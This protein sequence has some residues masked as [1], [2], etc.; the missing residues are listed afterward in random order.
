M[1]V[2]RGTNHW[3]Q[4][5]PKTHAYIARTIFFPTNVD[6]IVEAVT[7]AESMFTPV[8]A[9]GGGWSFTEASLPGGVVTNRPDFNAVDSMTGLLPLAEGFPP[10]GQTSIASLQANN[11]NLIGYDKKNNRVVGGAAANVTPLEAL[12]LGAQP[13]P[14]GIIDTSSLKSTLPLADILSRA[15]AASIAPGTGRHFFHVEAG[16]RMDALETLLDMQ[17]PRL[18]LGASGGNPGATLAGTLS[19]ATHGAEFNQDLLVDRVRAIH[20]VGPGGQQWWIEGD[21]PVASRAKLQ[22]K[23]PGIRV[24]AG[25]GR[26]GGLRPQDW[27]NAAVVSMGSIGV[28]YSVVIEVPA[29]GGFEQTTQQT[30][31][32]S[33]LGHVGAVLPGAPSAQQVLTI[34][35]NPSDP[36]FAQANKMIAS[37]LK[38][39]PPFVGMFNGGIIGANENFYADLAFNPNPLVTQNRDASPSDRDIWIV[40]R[41]NQ[42]IPFDPQPPTKSGLMDS[43]NAIFSRLKRAFGG[44]VAALVF[45]LQQIYSIVDPLH[46]DIP[47]PHADIA[48]VHADVSGRIDINP[49]V[50]ITERVNT[51]PHI[52]TPAAHVDVG[53]HVDVGPH[54]DTGF[55]FHADIS[56]HADISPH[57]DVSPHLDIAQHIDV[58]PH[59]DVAQHIDVAP[60]VDVAS[61]HI[62]L[63]PGNINIML[64]G[65]LLSAI[66]PLL[67][68]LNALFGW[69][70]DAADVLGSI[71]LLPFDLAK[72]VEIINRITGA[73]DTLDVALGELTGPIAD[74][75]ALDIAQPML[76]GLLEAVLGTANSSLGI[77]IGT[78][79]GAIGF[80]DSGLLGAGLEIAMPVETAFGFMQTRILDKMQNPKAPLFGY[81]SV[82]LC[83]QTTSLMGMQQWPTSVMIEV[84]GFGDSFGKAFMRQLQSDAVAFVAKGNDA[85]LHWGLENDQVTAG[86]L[87]QTPALL[88]PLAST[89]SLNQLGAFRQVRKLIKTNLGTNPAGL[90]PIFDNAFT[91][92]LAL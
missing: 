56:A 11:P 8:R 59:V 3:W 72:I 71:V 48:P 54:V 70:Q 77:S 65:L 79:V 28:I 68:V 80:P 66:N 39:E 12:L 22:T 52:D 19:T 30:T 21:R 61:P 6:E 31:W 33:F 86:L 37:A 90:F 34:L 88:K 1:T 55:G 41:R 89:P 24:I 35:R 4:N 81:I 51:T 49:H 15:G 38:A 16:I 40:N 32:I 91:T 63:S 60:H 17:S 44:N 42:P 9:V 29:L 45:R 87:N 36:L 84:V 57:V 78:S 46:V 82:R 83:P 85:M 18:Q 69:F 50:D 67:P 26:V 10:D 58:A 75:N 20:L 74:A 23:Y 62:D 76:T 7:T 43:V 5:W 53:Q 92:R 13:Q 2:A 27:L 25:S 64:T 47:L 73:N 14:V